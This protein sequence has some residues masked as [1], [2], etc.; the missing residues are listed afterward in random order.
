MGVAEWPGLA[1]NRVRLSGRPRQEVACWRG[2]KRPS[3]SRPTRNIDMGQAARSTAGLSF[4]RTRAVATWV[5]NA[6][7][8]RVENL[9]SDSD[10]PNAALGKCQGIGHVYPFRVDFRSRL[11]QTDGSMVYK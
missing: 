7:V 3:P 10:G 4:A 8:E 6:N 9:L 5:K 2:V 1:V 11:A